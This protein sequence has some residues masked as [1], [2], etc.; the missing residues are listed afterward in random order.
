MKRIKKIA[1]VILSIII[2]SSTFINSYAE[3]I[4]ITKE[5]LNTALQNFT[6]ISEDK[7]T[8]KI[9]MTEEAIK[10]TVN[11]KDYN[12]EYDLSGNPTFKLEIPIEKG[13]KYA[14]FKEKTDN[15][16]LP[17]IPYIAVANIQGV[18]IK[19]ATTYFFISYIK[20]P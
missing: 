20:M 12:L 15:I 7:G 2:L 6:S 10:I 9:K 16:I 1:I 11:E 8:Y 13:M 3:S 14:D 17:A 5:N 19:D 18:E 4:V